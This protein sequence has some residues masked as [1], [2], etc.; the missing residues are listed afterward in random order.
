MALKKFSALL[1]ASCLV[2]PS[3]V[4]ANAPETVEISQAQL[5]ALE[6][7]IAAKILSQLDARIEKEVE[8]RV[9]AR[10]ENSG[11]SN[12]ATSN[13][14]KA[15][16]VMKP[17]A[18]HKSKDGDF[19]FN[20]TGSFQMDTI[21]FDDD[22]AD[23]ATDIDFRRL[24]LG[25]EGRFYED[26]HYGIEADFRDNNADVTDA[27][28]GFDGIENTN[29]QIGQFKQP[30]SMDFLTSSKRY[31]FAERG[32]PVALS[33]G[34]G[35]GAMAQYSGDDWGVSGGFFGDTAG[36]DD[37]NDEQ[38]SA[39]ARL[40]WA[41]VLS[42]DKI[43]HVGVAGAYF[44]PSGANDDVRYRARA[45][46][47]AD[48]PLVDV[49]VTNVDDVKQYGFEFGGA[50]DALYWQAEYLNNH[51][52]AASGDFDFNGYYA[53]LVYA[54]TG[55]KRIYDVGD[56]VFKGI[57]P[58]RP[59]D[60]D[61]GHYGAWTI[62]ARYSNL[63]LNDGVLNGG[64]LSNWTVGVNWYPTR[65]TRFIFNYINADSDNNAVIAN[66]DPD[67]YVLRTQFDF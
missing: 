12:T 45:E 33:L 61:E 38:H 42:E 56:G 20:M 26:F 55:E 51:V 52:E 41:P 28:L 34:R 3:I 53:Q 21:I 25:A 59:F 14:D 6:E 46:A 9:Q 66:D 7:K 58:D 67:I 13:A 11:H 43:V 2:A 30:L 57:R 37:S 35:L 22:R 24:R 15:S 31:A 4:M 64:E 32:L 36:S 44:Y 17:V 18:V 40:H 49:T 48:D 54:L 1:I 65:H 39:I 8:K 19:S 47:R 63:D 16:T 27:Y 50:F 60:L 29:L 5:E 10:L 23:R 62:G